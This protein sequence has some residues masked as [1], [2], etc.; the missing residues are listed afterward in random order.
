MENT[1]INILKIKLASNYH[2]YYMRLV[3][4]AFK[5]AS[6]KF[7]KVPWFSGQ[8]VKNVLAVCCVYG[9]IQKKD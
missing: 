3:L 4:L 8:I 1:S 5:W 7:G 9:K 2:I 6:T